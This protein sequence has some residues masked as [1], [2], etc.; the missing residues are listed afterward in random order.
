MDGVELDREL[1]EADPGCPAWW[2]AVDARRLARGRKPRWS[3]HG[4]PVVAEYAAFLRAIGRAKTKRAR[5][6]ARR[7]WPAISTAHRIFRRN[8]SGRW[9]LEAYVLSGLPTGEVAARCQVSEEVVRVYRMLYLDVRLTARTWLIRN[10]IGVGPMD[11]FREVRQLWLWTALASGPLAVDHLVQTLQDVLVPGEAPSLLA[12]FRPDVPLR[13]QAFV[14]SLVIPQ[15]RETRQA[16]DDMHLRLQEAEALRDPDWR[17]VERDRLRVET[18]R[19]AQAVLQGR[20]L[21]RRRRRRRQA[22][23]LLKRLGQP[24]ASKSGRGSAVGLDAFL[25]AVLSHRRAP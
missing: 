13:V 9:L 10:V 18:I 24:A 22:A 12:Y 11:G 7:R 14:A 8:Q 15:C 5:L 4:D 2:R 1:R 3:P 25:D 20:P 16:W 21:P 17:E 23:E 19:M 6:A